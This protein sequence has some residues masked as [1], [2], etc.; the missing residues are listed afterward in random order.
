MS[1]TDAYDYTDKLKKEISN[2]GKVLEV[3]EDFKKLT[4]N[5]SKVKF[6]E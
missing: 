1:V 3:S 2:Q 5:A 6:V 4:D